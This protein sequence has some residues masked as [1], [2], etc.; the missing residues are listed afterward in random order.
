MRP[1]RNISRWVTT[2]ASF[3]VS[4]RIGRKERERRMRDWQNRFLRVRRVKPD[5]RQKD[6]CYQSLPANFATEGIGAR[7]PCRA[8]GRARR[9]YIVKPGLTLMTSPARS[10][11]V[12]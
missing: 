1:A 9:F 2:S 10:D 7:T 5:R 12:E 3:G 4:R 6:K 8:A 11:S